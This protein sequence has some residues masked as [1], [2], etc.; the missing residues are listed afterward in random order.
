MDGSIWQ[1]VSCTS[2][3]A[4]HCPKLKEGA[5]SSRRSSQ[6]DGDGLSV[7]RP[8]LCTSSAARESPPLG[9]NEIFLS[10]FFI[11]IVS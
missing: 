8:V 11:F 4:D 7:V 5:G 2:L 1:G 10:D 6:E 3:P 9:G